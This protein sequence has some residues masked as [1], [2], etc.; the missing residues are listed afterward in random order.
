M[1][2]ILLS[3]I[4][5]LSAPSPTDWFKASHIE[6]RIKDAA[7]TYA[8]VT[9]TTL[10]GDSRIEITSSTSGESGTILLIAGRWM[11]TKD[12][13]LAE[14]SEIDALDRA[15]LS[16]QLALTLLTRAFPKGPASVTKDGDVSIEEPSQP[17]TISTQSASGSFSAPWKVT[18]HVRHESPA[19]LAFDV[20]FSARNTP[21]IHLEG[22]AEFRPSTV[23]IGND[24][25][26]DGWTVYEIGPRTQTSEGKTTLDYGARRIERVYKTVGDLRAQS[27]MR[28]R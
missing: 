25:S 28:L 19:R 2:V 23:E 12:I 15:A 16:M 6:V 21:G 26:L 18:G 1:L 11:I 5:A 13:R 3:S 7:V 24:L 9:D 17:I 22:A 20:T 10:N 27:L 4:L 8:V 14:G